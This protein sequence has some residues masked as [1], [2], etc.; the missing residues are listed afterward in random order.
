MNFNYNKILGLPERLLLNKKLTK[1]FFLKNFDLSVN[2]KNVLNNDILKMDWISR[3][4]PSN[5]NIPEFKDENYFFEEVQIMLCTLNVNLLSAKSDICI[6]IFQKYIPYQIIL[7][8]EDND[9]FILNTAD[10][11]INLNDKSKRTVEKQFSTPIIPKLYKNEITT[12]FFESINYVNQ[13]KLTLQSF[14]KGYMDLIIQYKSSIVTGTFQK[15]N[16]ER[17]EIDSNLLETMATIEKEVNKLT[18]Q[19]K[20]ELQINTKVLMNIEIQKLR[21]EIEIIKIKLMINE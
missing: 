15:K 10:K 12:D 16:R 9:G 5:S 20:K 2:E 4:V 18:N 14:Y 21:K 13:D 3:L 1:T 8:V 11:R 7:I 19:I 17:S 6:T